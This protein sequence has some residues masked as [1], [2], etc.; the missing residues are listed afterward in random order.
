[1][2]MN[3]FVGMLAE[4]YPQ[5]DQNN[6]QFRKAYEDGERFVTAPGSFVQP[7]VDDAAA[8]AAA[9]AVRPAAPRFR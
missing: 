1:M 3:E 2:H 7:Q 8:A 5:I 6:A 4:T 9:P